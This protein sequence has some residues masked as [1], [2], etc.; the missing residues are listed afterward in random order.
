M[1]A[2]FVGDKLKSWDKY[3]LD[4]RFALNSAAH[5]PI[6]VTPAKLNVGRALKGPLDTELL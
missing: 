3:I 2:S 6:G 5:E 4:L 1:I